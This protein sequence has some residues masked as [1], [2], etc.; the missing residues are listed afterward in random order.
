MKFDDLIVRAAANIDES[1][2][3]RYAKNA[4]HSWEI[5]FCMRRFSPQCLAPRSQ[6]LNQIES[7]IESFESSESTQIYYQI[8]L[9]SAQPFVLD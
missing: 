8:Y 4:R 1:L 2:V 6:E 5:M 3:L 7:L 9:G